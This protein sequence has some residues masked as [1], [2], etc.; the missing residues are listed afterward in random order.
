MQPNKDD[1]YEEKAKYN[2]DEKQ[3]FV[4]GGNVGR[5]SEKVWKIAIVVLVVVNIILLAS[6]LAVTITWRNER[7]GEALSMKQES[8]MCLPC[9]DVYHHPDDVIQN[10]QGFEK[11]TEGDQYMCCGHASKHLDQLVSVYTE[12][13]HQ[14]E[15]NLKL[16]TSN[17]YNCKEGSQVVKPSAHL[18]GITKS[19]QDM[20]DHHMLKWN[21]TGKLSKLNEVVYEDGKVRV[22]S[23]GYY[24][25]YSQI[26]YQDHSD[27]SPYSDNAIVLHHSIHKEYNG[28]GDTTREKLL[29]SSQSR[30][31]IIGGKSNKTSYIGAVFYLKENDLIQVRVS[32]PPKLMPSEHSNYFGM[33]LT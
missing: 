29:E 22:K 32:H 10:I 15:K 16:L 13:A 31:Q 24:Y 9:E 6:I 33:Y 25:I 5:S 12:K 23:S 14:K 7:A 28:G 26:T 1:V 2:K 11:R 21:Q 30:C 8:I 20:H 4:N 19:I 18:V 17:P 27:P 3:E